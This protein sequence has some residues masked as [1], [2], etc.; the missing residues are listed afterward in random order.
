MP[1]DRLAALERAH[2]LR[3]LADATAAAEA[4]R[5]LALAALDRLREAAAE[6]D[7]LRERLHTA[8]DEARRLRADVREA[9]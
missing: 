3:E 4:Y 6:C 5:E 8:L 1:S 2:D 7:R 9:A